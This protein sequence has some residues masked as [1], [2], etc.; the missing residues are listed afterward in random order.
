MIRKFK[1]NSSEILEDGLKARERQIEVNLIH[2]F[3]KLT[4]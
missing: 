4:F 3:S 1:P 2:K